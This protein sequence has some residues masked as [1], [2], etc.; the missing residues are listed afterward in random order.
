VVISGDLTGKGTNAKNCG[1]DV[2]P[3]DARTCGYGSISAIAPSPLRADE[4]WVGTDDGLIQLTT[5]GGTHW[6]DVTPKGLPQWV[7]VAAIDVSSLRP[8][9]AYAAIDGHRVDDF[10]PHIFRTLDYG[11]NWQEISQSLPHDHFVNVV[12]ADPV[13]S[14]LLYCGTDAGVFVSFDDGA[15]WSP[16]GQRLPTA[17]VTD[18]LI[19][20]DDLV[21]ATQ[22]R[23]IWILDDV[24]PLRESWSKSEA[25]RFFMPATAWRVHPDNNADTPLPPES[26]VGENPPAGA[27]IDYWLGPNVRGPVTLEIRDASGAMV[28]RF[29]TN[30][31][32]RPPRAER[33]FAAAWTR[34]PQQLEASAGMH[35][36]IWNLRIDRPPAIKYS[37]SIA[38]VWGRDTPITPQG[39]YVPPG[40]YDVVLGVGEHTYSAPLT[41]AEDPRVTAT[42]SDLRESFSLSR[43]IAL[44]LGQART[45]YGERTFVLKRIDAMF[46]NGKTGDDEADD[47]DSDAPPKPKP[48]DPIHDLANQIRQTSPPGEPTFQSVDE[49]L[50]DIETDLES[51]DAAPTPA[52]HDAVE[53]AK[54]KLA[55]LQRHWTAIKAG[56]LPALN[57]ALVRV[58]RKP[59]VIPPPNALDSDPPAAGQDVP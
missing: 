43:R 33:Y 25:A 20:N 32:V 9:V 1:G 45:G 21:A 52:Q 51:V 15:H 46:P 22:G 48:I 17:S 11:R 44:L 37:Y 13:K 47:R 50:T 26:P 57:A 7:K 3:T 31:I 55:Q 5:D 41:I 18:L 29:A 53:D 40:K 28:R 58:G 24:G 2:K 35:R 12:R 59:I 34:P 14:E 39:P 8:G 36:F 6:S 19:H 38:A 49:I 54:L 42:L 56:P 27:I 10:H 4:I 16:L 30:T 23:A